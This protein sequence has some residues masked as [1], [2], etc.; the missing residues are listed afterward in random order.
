MPN[1]TDQTQFPER[2]ASGHDLDPNA[3]GD[4]TISNISVG[5]SQ[6]LVV[7]ANSVDSEDWSAS[8]DWVDT[9]GTTYQTQDK[10]ATGLSSVSDDWARLVRKAPA[11]TVTFTSEE[12]A[13]TQNRINAFLD[14]HE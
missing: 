12:T 13:G 10:A 14:T 6:A 7:A 8:V 11:A 4:L 9:D 2:R 3:D 1:T 5:M